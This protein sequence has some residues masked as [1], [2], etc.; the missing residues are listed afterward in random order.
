MAVPRTN[1]SGRTP[2]QPRE[3]ES[4]AALTAWLGQP[5]RGSNNEVGHNVPVALSPEAGNNILMLLPSSAVRWGK[6][7][8]DSAEQTTESLFSRKANSSGSGDDFLSGMEE[9]WIEIGCSVFKAQ[10]VRNIT[11]S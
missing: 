3:G 5:L 10:I 2:N 4:A 7:W 1:R 11:L 8:G 6:S 9:T